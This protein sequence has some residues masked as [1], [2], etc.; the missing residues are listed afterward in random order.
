M[1]KKVTK[2]VCITILFTLIFQVLIPMTM[3][4][5]VLAESDDVITE[6]YTKEDFFNFIEEANISYDT[7]E[8]KKI[9]LMNDIDLETSIENPCKSV[10]PAL[11]F[12]G[13]FDGQNHTI[14]N[15]Y[16]EQPLF[17]QANRNIRNLNIEN[18]RDPI[19]RNG[20]KSI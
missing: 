14:Y 16:L 11:G 6:I 18:A 5:K 8:G 3:G 13:D 1:S 2:I 4:I 9:R 19:K 15:L 17:E 20:R 12:Y 7:Y 10:N